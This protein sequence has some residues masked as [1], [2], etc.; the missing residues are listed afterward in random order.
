MAGDWIDAVAAELDRLENPHRDKKRATI[1]AI[2]DARLAGRS[3]ETVWHPRRPETCSRSV[4]HNKWKFEP[5][6]ADVLERTS[7]AARDY[8]DGRALRALRQAAE[9]LALASPVAVNTA[10]D[11]L[12]AEDANV[13]LRAAFGILDRAGIETS[14]KSTVATTEDD[15]SAL[16]DEERA[17]RISAILD[18]A[19]AR[20]LAAAGG[21]GHTNLAPAARP[22]GDGV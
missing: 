8:Q 3:E 18:A 21:D 7:K 20:R 14:T 17:S 13:R 16:S 10:I 6:F 5:V 22:A 15:A 19:R 2:V 11:A 4:Y 12:R 1:L 9:R